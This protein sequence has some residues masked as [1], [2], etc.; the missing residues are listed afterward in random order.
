MNR[1]QNIA[2]MLR[3]R[4]TIEQRVVSSDGGGGEIQQWNE[5]AR[6]WADVRP[7]NSFVRNTE[8]FRLGQT[9]VSKLHRITLRSRDDITEDMRVIYQ[10]RVLNIRTILIESSVS[11]QMELIV[12]EG[13]HV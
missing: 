2:S 9:Q 3:D 4:I 13:V 10:E 1:S 11:G 6:V 7:V 12:E 5:L 8:R